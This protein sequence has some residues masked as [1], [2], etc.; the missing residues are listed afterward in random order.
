[1]LHF[2]P[3]PSKANFYYSTKRQPNPTPADGGLDKI[4]RSVYTIFSVGVWRS[5]V[6]RT[7]RDGEVV[8]SNRIT[9]TRKL[10][11]AHVHQLE[12]LAIIKLKEVLCGGELMY[13]ELS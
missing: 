3:L 12:P 6:A 5:L 1:M 13:A 10:F 7:V 11:E 8:R 9:P 2:V 4:T